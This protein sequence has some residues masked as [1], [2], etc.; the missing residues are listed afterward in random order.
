MHRL[1]AGDFISF[2]LTVQGSQS[3]TLSLEVLV[4]AGDPP[5][6][7]HREEKLLSGFVLEKNDE[8]VKEEKM[9][10]ILGI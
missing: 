8:F 3:W 7:S 6:V 1:H 4:T 10:H 2:S 5:S 9:Y